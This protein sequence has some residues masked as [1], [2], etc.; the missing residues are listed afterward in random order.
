VLWLILTNIRRIVPQMMQMK[1]ITLLAALAICSS[2]WSQDPVRSAYNGL[3]YLIETCFAFYMVLKFDPEEISSLVTMAGAILALLGLLTVAFLPQFGLIRY[4]HGATWN[5]V[6]GDRTTA[7]KYLVFLLS[8][9]LVFR[10]RPFSYSRIIYIAVLSLMTFMAHAMTA[11]IVLLFYAAFMATIEI[12]KRF[13]RRSSLLIVGATLTAAAL[14]VC[15]GLPYLPRMLEGMGKN[16]TLTGRTEIWVLVANS[17]AKRPLLGYGYYAFWQG[18]KGESANVIVA[19]HWMFGYAHNGVLEI[20][21]QLGL[22]GTVLVFATLF[23]AIGNAWFCLRNGCPP[24]VEWY[25]GLIALTVVYNID[26]STILWPIDLL[27]ML[28]IVAC[29]GLARAARQIRSV[30]KIEAMYN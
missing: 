10:R 7:G 25:V 30:R 26:E 24:G 17:I 4:A 5:G 8:P 16:P 23:Q 28:Y 2:L 27:S 13:G 29:F 3:F 12:S 18:L 20:W 6:F 15:I 14:I 1:M 11:R 9:A 22:V 21:L 19:A